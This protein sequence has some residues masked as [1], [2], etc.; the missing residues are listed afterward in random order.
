MEAWLF[1][2]SVA[3]IPINTTTK[4]SYAASAWSPAQINPIQINQFADF[5]DSPS[6]EH[7]NKNVNGEN[8]YLIFENL[9]LLELVK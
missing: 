9:T 2:V 3:T 8:T 1:L 4:L 6:F 5:A 7:L